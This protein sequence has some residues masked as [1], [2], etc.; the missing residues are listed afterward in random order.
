ME[1]AELRSKIEGLG[2]AKVNVGELEIS[3]DV[4]PQ[5]TDI[6]EDTVPVEMADGELV[7]D[8]HAVAGYRIE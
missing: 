1:S 6:C 7:F 5:D 3:C 4:H 2:E 8:T